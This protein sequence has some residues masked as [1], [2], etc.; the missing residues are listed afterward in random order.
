MRISS[1]SSPINAFLLLM[2]CLIP[3]AFHNIVPKPISFVFFYMA[4]MTVIGIWFTKFICGQWAIVL[5]RDPF[6]LFLALFLSYC[7][8]HGS[9]LLTD[10][11]NFLDYLKY[12]LVFSSLLLYY[13]LVSSIN[14][15]DHVKQLITTLILISSIICFIVFSYNLRAGRLGRV[16]PGLYFST[17]YI[18]VTILLIGFWFLKSKM[19]HPA[20]MYP[21]LFIHLSRYVI[22]ARRAPIFFLFFGSMTKKPL[23][24]ARCHIW[25]L[26][27][28][29]CTEF[30]LYLPY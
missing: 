27:N 7:L 24:T 25:F 8:V 13:V 20:I 28:R 6:N 29:I 11:V 30:I 23:S 2:L 22:D 12:V 9:F 16:E 4:F 19:V 5:R 26:V 3:G 21:A 15:D 17:M 14:N 18:Y 1:F 10:Y